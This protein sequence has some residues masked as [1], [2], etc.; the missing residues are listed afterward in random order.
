MTFK[1]AEATG[2]SERTVRRI[3]T[4]KSDISGTAFTS[5]A[6]R[7]KGDRKKIVQDD[8]N[9]EALLRLVHGFCREKKFPTCWLLVVWSE[10]FSIFRTDANMR[11]NV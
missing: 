1:T 6:K 7:Y 5:P 10:T 2:Y 8:F 11:Y 9:T 4:E 3:V